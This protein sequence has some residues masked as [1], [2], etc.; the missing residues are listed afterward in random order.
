MSPQILYHAL[1]ILGTT[2]KG[3]KNIDASLYESLEL[4]LQN[5]CLAL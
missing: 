5:Q 4:T 3:K 1:E 2:N